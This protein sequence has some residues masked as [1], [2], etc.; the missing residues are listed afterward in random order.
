MF[1]TSR[2]IHLQLRKFCLGLKE[3]VV[4]AILRDDLFIHIVAECVEKEALFNKCKERFLTNFDYARWKQLP[5]VREILA[6]SMSFRSLYESYD[7]ILLMLTKN[8]LSTNTEQAINRIIDTNKSQYFFPEPNYDSTLLDNQTKV[9]NTYF[10]V[11][12]NRE[13]TGINKNQIIFHG[14]YENYNKTT[15]I[16]MMDET[17]I[18]ENKK[19]L[20]QKFII[21]FSN[22]FIQRNATIQ[23]NLINQQNALKTYIK[24]NLFKTWKPEEQTEP[25]KLKYSNERWKSWLNTH[26]IQHQILKTIKLDI[27]IPNRQLKLL[28]E[29]YGIHVIKTKFKIRGLDRESKRGDYWFYK[30]CDKITLGEL[31]EPTIR[32][33]QM[34]HDQINEI[35]QG[36]YVIQTILDTNQKLIQ[37]IGEIKLLRNEKPKFLNWKKVNWKTTKPNKKLDKDTD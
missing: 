37:N 32:R 7:R 29:K 22:R 25:V 23:Q 10:E 36:I 12:K 9:K 6:N 24:N 13:L 3:D 31:I 2:R 28:V 11:N 30:L 14:K 20:E 15:A 21:S 16:R 34:I 19:K 27:I 18:E 35:Q 17:K 26:R 1:R 4:Y 8:A 33:S 5:E